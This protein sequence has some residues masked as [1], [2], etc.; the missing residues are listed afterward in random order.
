MAGEQYCEYVRASGAG[1]L[2]LHPKIRQEDLIAEINA[3]VP[4]ATN[5]PL[6]LRAMQV[7]SR[8]M[9]AMPGTLAFAPTQVQLV[10]LVQFAMALRKPNPLRLA[11]VVSAWDRVELGTDPAEW[12]KTQLPLLHQYLTVHSDTIST[13]CFGISAQGGDFGVQ[14]EA[15]KL[16]ATGTPSSRILVCDGQYQGSDIARP[17]T[18]LLQHSHNAS[19]NS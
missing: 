16:R 15:E 3:L 17:L 19:A 8:R 18:W 12:V 4:T 9:I 14:G 11:I 10:D 13:R 5:A 6:A 2:F 7:P 1:L